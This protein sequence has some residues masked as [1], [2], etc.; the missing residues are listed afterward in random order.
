MSL[1]SIDEAIAVIAAGGMVIVVDGT[2]GL[3]LARASLGPDRM[4]RELAV[5]A[6]HNRL[7][8]RV[9]A[10]GVLILDA[11]SLAVSARLPRTSNTWA[12]E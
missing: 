3:V 2:N 12:H 11:A 10:G 4:V 7:L 8:A 6:A 9:D 1:A 5:D